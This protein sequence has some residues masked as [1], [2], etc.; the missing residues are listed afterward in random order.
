MPYNDFESPYI[1]NKKEFII[2]NTNDKKIHITPEKEVIT[3]TI[4]SNDIN[5]TQQNYL[6]SNGNTL[7]D[8]SD[9][10]SNDENFD[11]TI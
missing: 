5:L 7:S 11:S 6:H 1:T 4:L 2:T 10:E 3:D 8:S 9:Q